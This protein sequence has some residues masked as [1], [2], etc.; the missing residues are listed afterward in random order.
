MLLKV[1]LLLGLAV[2]G[3]HVWTI[4]KEFVNVNKNHDYFVASV[5]FAVARFND[6]NMEENAYRLLEVGRAQQKRWTM[7]FL[8]DLEIG[9]TI[10]KKHSKDIDNCPFKEGP[11]EKQVDCT[12]IV[13]ARPWFSQFT[14]LNSTC[15]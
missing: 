3:T 5:E 2:L 6:D 13:D 1:L 12:F 4:Q 9:R 15:V 11:E 8:M 7:I 10:C 14:L